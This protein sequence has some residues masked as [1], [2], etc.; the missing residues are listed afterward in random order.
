MPQGPIKV[1]VEITGWRELARKLRD[2]Q[3]LAGPWTAAMKSAADIALS[4][5]QGASPVSSGRMR[6]SMKSK[7]QARPVPRWAAVRTSATRSS[8]KYKR[9]RYPGRQEYDPRS[10]NKG[11]LRQALVQ[12]MGRIQGVLSTTARMVEAKWRT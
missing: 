1:G 11:R 12:A 4:A 3:L 9:Y 2:D 10:R 5:W 7:V 8:R 6:A